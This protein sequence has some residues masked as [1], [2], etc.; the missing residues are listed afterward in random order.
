MELV[1]FI[2]KYCDMAKLNF[3]KQGIADRVTVTNLPM[4][5]YFPS[6]SH[7]CFWFQKRVKNSIAMF[8]R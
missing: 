1:E 6:T 4:E 5:K 3:S 8:F 2:P 7:D